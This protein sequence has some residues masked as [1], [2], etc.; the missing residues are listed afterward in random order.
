MV[1]FPL[2]N[3]LSELVE[4]LIVF[5]LCT[6]KGRVKGIPPN[7]LL[8]QFGIVGLLAYFKADNRDKD[9]FSLALGTDLTTLGLSLTSSE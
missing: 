2:K 8:D 9:L 5:Y 3:K 6:I 4:T 7:M 1:S